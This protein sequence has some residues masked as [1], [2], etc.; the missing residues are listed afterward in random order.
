MLKQRLTLKKLVEF[1][2]NIDSSTNTFELKSTFIPQPNVKK[3]N[4]FRCLNSND[5][6]ITNDLPPKL[7]SYFDP[8]IKDFVR[9]HTITNLSNS[10]DN[11][12]VYYSVLRLCVPKF[13]EYSETEQINYILALRGKLIAYISDNDVFKMNGYEN[14]KWNRKVIIES[15]M[16]FKA[17]KLTLKV[18]A[19]FFSINIFILNIL[20]DKLYA[21][22][23]NDFY[24]M[25]RLNVFIC[26]NNETFE[27]LT[28]LK[29]GCLEYKNTLVKK[30]V[31]IHKNIVILFNT[32]MEDNTEI[33]FVIKQDT[34]NIPSITNKEN[35][36]DDVVISE[37]D[38]V[39][40]VETKDNNS[41]EVTPEPVSC[42]TDSKVQGIVFNVSLKMKLEELQ[43]MAQ[44]LNID[45]EK[46]QNNKKKCK[47]K[48]ELVED[49]NRVMTK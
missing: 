44:K 8:F 25:F 9:H 28:Y 43:T 31:S 49:I 39:K 22:S 35:D 6:K 18:I 3:N 16:K 20:E 5:S 7:R 29:S 41:V 1:V 14:L 32:N 38:Y 23:G 34:F 46:I 10:N 2:K 48:N 11:V 37:V 27:P 4:L 45:I 21:V 12:S 13:E 24:D 30:I 36:Y 19:D 40:D 17:T 26:L 47:T 33:E 42:T 15:L